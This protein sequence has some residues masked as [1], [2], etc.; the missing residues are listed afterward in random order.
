MPEGLGPQFP[1]APQVYSS[2]KRLNF[3]LYI[4]VET[5]SAT[6]S[7]WEI[8]NLSRDSASGTDFCWV[9]LL[10]ALLFI[11]HPVK[12]AT[13]RRVCY[14]VLMRRSFD[15]VSKELVVRNVQKALNSYLK[16]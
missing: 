16:M 15:Q 2:V 7:K 10:W 6:L 11:V 3:S 14:D 5:F 13:A 8:G 4:L 1:Y 9:Y 12:P